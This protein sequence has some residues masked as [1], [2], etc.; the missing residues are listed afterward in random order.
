LR[1]VK[2]AK[3]P[4]AARILINWFLSTEFQNVGWY[5]EKPGAEAINHWNIT[6]DKYLV[7][8]A[9]GVAPAHREAQPDW[10]KPFYPADPG[11]LILPINWA[12]YTPQVE[13]ISKTY[14]RIVKGS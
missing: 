3:H 8:Y 12:W 6:K 5:K 13:W 14:D 4:V 10:A 2:G 11:K 1:A 9:G 7:A